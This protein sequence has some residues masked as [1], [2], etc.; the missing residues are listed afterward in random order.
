MHVK[1]WYRRNP[2]EQFV[3]K[4]SCGRIASIKRKK[5][6][7]TTRLLSAQ[8]GNERYEDKQQLISWETPTST[9]NFL[10]MQN[11]TQV[12]TISNISWDNWDAKT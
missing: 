11:I 9:I 3:F 5:K 2:D 7:D 10:L 12:I 4:L 8:S 6:R 1:S